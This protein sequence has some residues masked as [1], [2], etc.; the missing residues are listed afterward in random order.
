MSYQQGAVVVAPDPFN[1]SGERPFVA[2][3]NEQH[4]FHDEEQIAVV[5]TTTERDDAIPIDNEEFVDGSLPRQSYLSPWN[6]VT[7]KDWMVKKHVATV[8]R[9]LVET[10]VSGLNRYIGS[11]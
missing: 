6:P 7:L 2:I 8:Q 11:A 4:P 3:S 9:S 5:V 10:A 1:R